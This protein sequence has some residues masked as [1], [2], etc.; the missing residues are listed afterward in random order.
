MEL[1]KTLPSQVKITKTGTT[2][3]NSMALFKCVCCNQE[4][5]R[6]KQ[7][8]LLAQTCGSKGCKPSGPKTGHGESGTELHRIWSS[9]VGY[10]KRKN[11][12]IDPTWLDYLNFK[13][14]MHSTYFEEAKLTRKNT[15]EAYSKSNCLWVNP[16]EMLG[17]PSN[18]T[19]VST[20]TGRQFEQH[21]MHDSRPYRIWRNMRLRCS[22]TKHARYHVYGG[23][24]IKVCNDWDNSFTKFWLDMQDGY[25]DEMTIDRINSNLGYAKENC[26]WV[27]LKENSSRSRATPTQQIDLV[28]KCVVKVW[29]SAREA[30]LELNIDPSSI[31][32]VVLGKKKSAGGFGWVVVN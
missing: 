12:L 4:V 26:R 5:E 1:L 17:L 6:I 24:G 31:T 23:K 30:G 7:V 28:T 15:N 19:Q 21:N 14:D 11:Q 3:R 2:K 18:S 29:N 27:T 22:D 13:T 16:K 9:M 10:C 32:K 20:V 8:G 25:T